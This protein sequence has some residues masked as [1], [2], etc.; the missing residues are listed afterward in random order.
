MSY[1]PV[2]LIGGCPRSGTTAIEYWLNAD[3][4][5]FISNEQNMLK[6]ATHVRAIL[7]GGKLDRKPS[8][9]AG[10]ALSTREKW[11]A[12]DWRNF[13]FFSDFHYRVVEDIYRLH[14]AR[15]RAEAPL[16]LFGDKFPNYFRKLGEVFDLPFPVKYLHITRNPYDVVDSMMR[17]TKLAEHGKD[18]WKAHT[19]LD[20]MIDTWNYALD[21]I[22]KRRTDERCLHVQYE[23]LIFDRDRV[24]ERV[25]DFVGLRL[26]TGF[27]F[28][29]DPAKHFDRGHLD[30][31][32]MKR[33][34]D[35]AHLE[36][37]RKILSE[38]GTGRTS[39][40]HLP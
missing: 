20:D 37:Y 36:A 38:S 7:G 32:A 24:Y 23:D 35:R 27:D 12:E 33:I 3:P 2:L 15:L 30:D 25:C 29:D 6:I 1:C 40:E 10:R 11:S 13:K 16:L 14:H 18:N 34:A 28:E 17:R 9:S 26:D 21:V 31:E 19:E 8:K 39:L 5:A 4:R 22:R